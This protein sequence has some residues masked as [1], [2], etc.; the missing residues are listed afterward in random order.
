MLCRD[1]IS[2]LTRPLQRSQIEILSR[3]EISLLESWTLPKAGVSPAYKMYSALVGVATPD[4]TIYVRIASRALF[5]A[6]LLLRKP[7]I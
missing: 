5:S 7:L 6:L 4:R 2:I 1:E 3:R